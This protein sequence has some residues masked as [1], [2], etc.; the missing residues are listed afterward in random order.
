LAKRPLPDE[1]N[2]IPAADDA[3]GATAFVR[4]EDVKPAPSKLP[5]L[6]QAP[7]QGAPKKGLQVTLPDD[8]PPPPPPKPKPVPVS[9]KKK[10]RRGDWWNHKSDSG[11][12]LEEEV[13]ENE[14]APEPEPEPEPEPAPEHDGATAFLKVEAPPPPPPRKKKAPPREEPEPAPVDNSTQFYRPE[15]VVL[16][17]E[18]RQR[19]APTAPPEAGLPVKLLLKILGV[20]LLVTVL[21]VVVIYRNAFF[22]PSK[23]PAKASTKAPIEDTEEKK[24]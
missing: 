10:G 20:F 7:A 12:D 3:P 18:V 19:P 23:R 16:Q 8:D 13:T 4:I 17:A 1:D 22:G 11:D 15:Q 5:P 24:E 14:P 6:R 21:S 2:P 9:V